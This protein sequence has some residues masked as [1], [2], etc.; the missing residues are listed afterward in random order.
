MS[1]VQIL[2]LRFFSFPVLLFHNLRVRAAPGVNSGVAA[3]VFFILATENVIS[4]MEKTRLLAD[5]GDRTLDNGLKVICLRKSGAPVVSV[6]LWYKTGSA[7]EVDGNRGISHFFEHMMFRGS[8]NVGSE[9]HARRINDVGGHYN[10]FSAE[11]VTAYVNSVPKQHLD[12]VLS[13]ESDRMSDLL[14]SEK[15]LETERNVIVEEFQTYMNNPLTKAFLEFRKEFF[16][17]HPYEYSA[18]G[19]LED[20]RTISVKDCNE[21]Y[22][23]WYTPNNALLVVVGDFGDREEVF[24]K[25]A[26]HFRRH[27][28]GDNSQPVPSDQPEHRMFR[29]KRDVDFDVPVCVIGYPAPSAS[30]KDALPLEIL[31]L[32][33]SQGE[34]SRMHREIVRRQSTAI[35]A[36]GMN[37]S[38]KR[39]GMSLFFAV[40][41]P[42][43]SIARVEDAIVKEV[44]SVRQRGISA[45]EIEKVKN[46][47]LTNR[48]FELYSADHI[49]Q[50]IAYSETI[51]GNYQRW[52]E[53]LA[54]LESLSVDTLIEAARRHW[55][56]PSRH[57]LYLKPKKVNPIL[58]AFG[59]FRKLAPKR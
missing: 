52:V 46:T 22:R 30:H 1:E 37:Q 55:A 48:V 17:D 28:A 35:M 24:E 50:K 26:G 29:M 14:V 40:F 21:Y 38:L 15:V 39:A 43:V 3:R 42:N 36:G 44:E 47:V 9:E 27:A 34:S 16:K 49:C 56:E 51:E 7:N 41:T 4:L 20:I 59:M 57:T 10:A 25:V 13:L 6:Q 12:M 8:K 31:Q 2:S 11:D 45:S 54:A 19:R 33:V 53:R 32:V 23:R 18:L 58:F 5:I